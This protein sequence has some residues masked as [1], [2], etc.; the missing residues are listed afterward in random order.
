MSNIVKRITRILDR[1]GLGGYVFRDDDNK[2]CYID[3]KEFSKE[4][5][6]TLIDGTL[7]AYVVKDK[8]T[9]DFVRLTIGGYSLETFIND[10]IPT[11]DKDN[12][13][14]LSDDDKVMLD[15]IH[16][17]DTAFSH[18]V[19]SDLLDNLLRIRDEGHYDGEDYSDEELR[20]HPRIYVLQWLYETFNTNQV[21]EPE[22]DGTH[23]ILLEAY[24]IDDL[25]EKVNDKLQEGYVLYGD[26][27]SVSDTY[28]GNMY[29]S[30]AVIKEPVVKIDYDIMKEVL[31]QLKMT[32]AV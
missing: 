11:L 27:I 31:E 2:I 24:N 18:W 5:L 4:Y 6:D 10:I 12:I 7:L 32:K 14:N 21:E 30:Q 13:L 28:R 29:Y 26:P 8:E 17:Y 25:N 23:Y 22:I 19:G 3:N 15:N 9:Y 16:E 1:K 20:M